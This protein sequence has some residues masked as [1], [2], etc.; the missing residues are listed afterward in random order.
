M[1]DPKRTNQEAPEEK[2]AVQDGTVQGRN[3]KVDIHAPAGVGYGDP[4]PGPP[5]RGEPGQPPDV[6]DEPAADPALQR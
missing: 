6:S 3:G 4:V 5:S 1:D 2:T